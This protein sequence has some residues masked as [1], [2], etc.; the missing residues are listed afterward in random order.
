MYKFHQKKPVKN[1]KL[2]LSTFSLNEKEKLI[3]TKPNQ[4]RGQNLSLTPKSTISTFL[5]LEWA[6]PFF[7]EVEN[8]IWNGKFTSGTEAWKAHNCNSSMKFILYS[9]L[10]C[11]LPCWFMVFVLKAPSLHTQRLQCLH[12]KHRSKQIKALV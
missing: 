9:G 2:F 8:R 4:Q 6:V 11:Y 5:L 3:K 7:R 10:K 1:D 12:C